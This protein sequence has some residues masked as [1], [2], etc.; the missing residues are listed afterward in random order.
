MRPLRLVVPFLA[1][2]SL[3]CFSGNRRVEQTEYT[4]VVTQNTAV[5]AARGPAAAGPLAPAGRV[6]IEA[7]GTG[8]YF[9]S[10][11]RTPMEGGPGQW[12]A[13]DWMGGRV[14]VGVNDWFELGASGDASPLALANRSSQHLTR[15]DADWL[16][17][18]SL[19][20]R[21]GPKLGENVRFVT[22][23]EADIV[24]AP[25]ERRESISSITTYYSEQAPRTT[26][27]DEWGDVERSARL[28]WAARLGAGVHG[29]VGPAS[30]GGGVAVQTMPV[31]F[32]RDVVTWSCTSWEDGSKDCEDPGTTPASTSSL[33]TSVYAMAA[34]RFSD[35][36]M[37]VAQPWLNLAGDD[38]D[39]ALSAP[40][41]VLVAMRFTSAGPE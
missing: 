11:L 1:A 16:G 9:Q 37:L 8:A 15:L 36:V 22:S 34:Y 40:A 12:T 5:P 26:E 14:S 32:G 3:A 30:F 24:N 23:L 10:P 28:Q 17:R 20:M 19:Q 18:G 7:S 39:A 35:R 33:V 13:G 27:V 2:W 38:Q 25:Y 41:G 6:T 21:F 29:D 4:R 31:F